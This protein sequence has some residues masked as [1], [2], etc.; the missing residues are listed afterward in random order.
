MLNSLKI[1]MLNIHLVLENH[2]V[3][4]I[5]DMK[6]EKEYKEFLAYCKFL[7]K[8]KVL[9]LSNIIGDINV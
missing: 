9:D 2:P 7:H 5:I 3:K 4:M 8:A 1:V 6:T